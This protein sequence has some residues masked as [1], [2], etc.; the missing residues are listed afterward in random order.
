[1]RL[2][3]PIGPFRVDIGYNP[4]TPD[5]GPAFFVEKGDILAGRPGRVIC[6]SPG[7]SEPVSGVVSNTFVCPATYTPGQK[8]G[9]LPRLTFH[10]SIGNAF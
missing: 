2:L 5:A 8:G 4:Y 10:F 6:V 9:L 3:T 7:S 1:V